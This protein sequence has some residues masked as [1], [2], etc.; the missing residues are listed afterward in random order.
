MTELTEEIISSAGRPPIVIQ[1]R[2]NGAF[3]LH[4]PRTIVALD[5]DEAERLASFI[6]G[7]PYIQRHPVATPAKARFGQVD[8]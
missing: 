2:D 6:T 1:R 8:G 4:A 3:W 7:R 5:A